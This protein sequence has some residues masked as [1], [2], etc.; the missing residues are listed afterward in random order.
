MD[1]HL[2]DDKLH[3]VAA[4]G[5]G[6]TTLGI[7]VI[8]RLNRPSLILCPTNTIKNQWK[9]RIRTS[10]LQEKDYG[11][12]STDI[13]KPG[14]ITVITYQALLA[15]FCGFDEEP[16]DNR[17]EDDERTEKEYTITASSRF[18][19]DKAEDIIGILKSAEVSLL[20]FD[21]AHHLRKEWWKALTYLNEHL[22]PEQTLA[23]TATPPYDADF[24]EWKRYQTLCGDIDEVISIPELV[25]NGDLCPHQDFIHFSQLHQR[26]R[27]LLENHR[28]HVN[29]MLE[30]LREDK[31]LQDLLAGMR[32]LR[33]EDEDTEAILDDPEFYVS[34]ASL[35]NENGYTIPSRFLGLFDASPSEI[36]RF[37][38][39]Q[40]TVFLNG[41]LYVEKEEWKDLEAIR[42]EY[43]NQAKRTGLT[44][45]KKF[46][47]DG[48]EKFCRQI[49]GSIGKLDSIVSIVDLESRLLKEDLRM[50]ILADF[51]R[52]NDQDCST[53]GVVPTWRKLKDKFQGS[54]SL[55]VLCG[56]L[57]L[58]PKNTVE[59]LQKL[60]SEN[61]IA[62][63]AIT[64]DHFG[65]DGNY[66]RIVPKEGIRNHIV[67][68]VTDM[69]NAG[70]LTVL[71]GTQ[72]L[73]GEGWDAPSINSLI[74]SS[75]VSSYMLSNQMRGRAIRIDR[76]HPDKVSNIWHLA[77][78]DP[79]FGNYSYDLTQLATRFEGYEAPSYSGN[80]EIVSGI[81]RVLMPNPLGVPETN[82]ALAKNRNLTRRWWKDA[83]FTGYGN[84]P[85]IGLST[86]V[87]AEALT[88]RSLRY[89]GY[90][91]Y[92]WLLLPLAVLTGTVEGVMKQIA[93]VILETLSDQGLIKTSIKQVGL[94]VHDEKG[95][96]FV[97]CANLPA[98]ENNLFI[99]SLQEFLDPV[100][101]PRYLLV[102]HT[103]F[104]K[105]IRQTDY[106]AIPSAISPNKKGVEIFKGLWKL[107]IGDCDIIYTRS[108]EGRRVLL[109][110][111]KYAFSAINKRASKRLSK[112]Q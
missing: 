69:F 44:D 66:V 55:G 78:Y 88:V 12:V 91:Y 86:G 77:T 79:K 11:I 40:A 15:A 74:L 63:D 13:R 64:L 56:S 4:P 30:K 21:E 72:A 1:F 43:F 10:F 37:D 45:G 25:K 14:Y 42:D 20:C 50:V 81:E 51:I 85:P 96:L 29:I 92:I 31:R 58:L 18:R 100:E 83:L 111:R 27:E 61:G 54:I 8:S 16:E 52:M 57:I 94:K 49:A 67:R 59:R 101:N 71:V 19:M 53:L 90:M 23:L 32:F 26:E 97:S 62:D 38:I 102:R 47:L 7:E 95:E 82:I 9:E 104:L 33:A 105:K 3:V 35:L 60:I 68:L 75:T 73:L 76:N 112:W 6:K 65:G 39:K 110:A 22:K 98:D 109:K 70:N 107:Y 84:T 103:R 17:P 87:Q 106:F 24:N 5:A 108:A 99:Q 93:I 89:T 80:H 28:Q 34:I 41:F 48:N 2:R 36:P 46:V